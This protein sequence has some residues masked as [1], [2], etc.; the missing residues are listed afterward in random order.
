MKSTKGEWVNIALGGALGGIG[1]GYAVY[2]GNYNWNTAKF[3]GNV[4]TGALIGGTFGAAGA[5]AGGGLSL[6]A[7][8]W[9][10]NSFL[11]NFGV[12]LGW[13]Q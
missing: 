13:R 8:V 6:G 9:R 3:A 12:N 10:A 5:L 2:A 7:N 11:A 4:A 1:Y